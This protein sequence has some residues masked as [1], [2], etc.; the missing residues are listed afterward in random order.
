MSRL[1]SPTKVRKYLLEVASKKRSHKF[2]RVSKH[3]IEEL[4]NGLRAK[5]LMLVERAPSKGKTL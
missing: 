5:C 1:I 4:E 2:T 3:T